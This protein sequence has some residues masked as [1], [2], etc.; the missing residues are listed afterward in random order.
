MYEGTSKTGRGDYNVALFRA[1]R[2]CVMGGGG[3]HITDDGPTR[4][5][6]LLALMRV[7]LLRDR[8]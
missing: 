8:L 3:G 1:P 4:Y 6:V 7:A 5:I 2:D